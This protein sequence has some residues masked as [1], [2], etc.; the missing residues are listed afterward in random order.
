MARHKEGDLILLDQREPPKLKLALKEAAA[1]VGIDVCEQIIP[2]GDMVLVAGDKVVGIERKTVSD[3]AGSFLEGRVQ[4]QLDGLRE[5][6]D[7]PYLLIEGEK[8]YTRV[9]DRLYLTLPARQ[10][11]IHFLSMENWLAG[12]ALKSPVVSIRQTNNLIET[13][14]WVV[15]FHGFLEKEPSARNSGGYKRA[16]PE[17]PEIMALCAVP[18]IGKKAAVDLLGTFGNIS[19]VITASDLELSR[20]RG[21][22]KVTIDA[23]RRTFGRVTE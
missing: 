5:S 18:G 17:R 4:K 11:K 2:F 23:L 1:S 20:I 15:A 6:C 13:I 10:T 12:L 9:D 8:T 3:L 7:I 22:G 19:G 21:V 16:A 14:T